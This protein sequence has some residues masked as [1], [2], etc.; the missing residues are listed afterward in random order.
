MFAEYV[1]DQLLS[2]PCYK[3]IFVNLSEKL[4]ISKFN[5]KQYNNKRQI[6]F[7]VDDERIDVRTCKDANKE[8]KKQLIQYVETST[9]DKEF[10]LGIFGSIK[11]VH[12]FM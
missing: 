3:I 4:I 8:L 6:I 5:P 9:L 2:Q 7:K 11:E 12:D 1:Y 10:I